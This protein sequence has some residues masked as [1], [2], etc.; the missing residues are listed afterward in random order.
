[1]WT[2]PSTDGPITIPARISSTTEGSLTL[3]KKP[4]SSG[5]AKATATTISRLSNAG[6]GS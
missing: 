4:S 2:I 6:M 3:G 1:M 5:P